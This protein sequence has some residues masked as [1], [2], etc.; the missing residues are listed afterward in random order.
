MQLLFGQGVTEKPNG[1]FFDHREAG[2]VESDGSIGWRI[3][4]VSSG[5]STFGSP[6]PITMSIA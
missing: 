5:S 6:H 3:L 1:L 2:T 4:N